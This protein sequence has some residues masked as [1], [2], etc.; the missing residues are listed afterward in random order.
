MSI[1]GWPACRYKP[2]IEP[3]KYGARMKS[4]N[5]FLTCTA[6]PPLPRYVVKCLRY[7][8]DALQIQLSTH[9]ASIYPTRLHPPSYPGKKRLLVWLCTTYSVQLS[10]WLTQ[11]PGNRRSRNSFSAGMYRLYR[12][13]WVVGC[14]HHL[15]GC[16]DRLVL[17][18]F[19]LRTS[20]LVHVLL[21][22]YM[23]VIT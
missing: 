22:G 8:L 14:I 13:N 17:W 2:C 21:H 1:T 10:T 5:I 4:I 9:M 3:W 23:Y 16:I 6:Q 7:L 18:V 15:N 20:F 11:N 12:W 19:D